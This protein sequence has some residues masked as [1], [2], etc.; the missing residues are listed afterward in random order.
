M[1]EGVFE[2]TGR[3]PIKLSGGLLAKEHPTSATG[4]SQICGLNWQMRASAGE[5]QV[6]NPKVGV[7][8]CCGGDL[9]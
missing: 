6:K 4:I 9:G 3:I 7:S 2:I 1:E 5:R 8:H